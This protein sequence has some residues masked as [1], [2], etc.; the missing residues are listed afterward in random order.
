MTG[1]NILKTILIKRLLVASLFFVIAF[2]ARAQLIEY[3]GGIGTLNYSGD[4]I[5]GFQVS[6]VTPGIFGVY[7]LNLSHAVSTRFSLTYGSLQGSDQNPIDPFAQVRDFDFR[8]NILELS[9]A[10][11]YYFLDFKSKHAV[12]KW[13]PYVFGGFALFRMYGRDFRDRD[14]RSIQPS[15][16]F[17]LGF[18][19]LIGRKFSVGVEYGARKTFFDQ[20]DDLGEGDQAL[21]NFQYGNPKD[22][23][24]YHFVGLSFTYILWDIPC[25][26][27][28]KPNGSIYR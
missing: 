10:F 6:N 12:V 1:I 19:H 16:P 13:S 2:S 17:G 27:P 24:W 18:K 28:Y 14:Y 15:I 22:R 23:D 7:R 20:L 9:G 3:G 26:F 25:P 5:R 11:E 4:L 8:V 21:K